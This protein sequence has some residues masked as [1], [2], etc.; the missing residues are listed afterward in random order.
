MMRHLA[1]AV[2]LAPLLLAGCAARPQNSVQVTLAELRHVEPDLDEAQVEHGLDQA[3]E[4]YRRFL[5]ETPETEMTPEAM[6]RLADLQ[7]EKQFGIH[8]GDEVSRELAAPEPAQ[9]VVDRSVPV[10][11]PDTTLGDLSESDQEFEQRTTAAGGNLGESTR[12]AIALYDR[13]R[14]SGLREQRPGP[15]PESQGV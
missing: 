14:V 7:I 3:M 12:E 13:L 5:E 2:L 1:I 4:G 11:E 9:A 6:R 15:V 10:Q 8:T